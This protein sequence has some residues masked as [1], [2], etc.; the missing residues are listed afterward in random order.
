M[1]YEGPTDY[2]PEDFQ[3]VVPHT[4]GFAESEIRETFEGAGLGDVSYTF[5]L[6]AK[7]QG[8]PDADVFTAYGKKPLSKT[9]ETWTSTV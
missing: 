9:V 7:I 2:V 6:R 4:K 5:A 8:Q 3:H 1:K